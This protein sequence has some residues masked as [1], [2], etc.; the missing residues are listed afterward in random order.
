MKMLN[1]KN[2]DKVFY[3]P[4]VSIYEQNGSYFLETELPGVD[5]KNVK[6]EVDNDTLTIIAEQEEKL[7]N[8]NQVLKERPERSFKRSFTLDESIDPD[9]IEANYNNGVLALKLNKRQELQPKKIEI[10]VAKE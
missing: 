8:Y 5:K 1:R 6:V 4:A 3:T 9:N 7:K 2:E 10:S